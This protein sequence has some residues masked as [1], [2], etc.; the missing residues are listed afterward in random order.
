MR[1]DILIRL[2]FILVLAAACAHASVASAK[3]KR[4]RSP[5]E[6]SRQVV[7]VTTPDWTSVRGTLRRFERKGARSKWTQVGPAFA[8][9]VGRSGLGCG[10]GLAE[11]EGEGPSKREG[12][13]RAPAG[14]FRL[15]NAF[16]F[17]DTNAASWLRL[18]YTPLT[19]AVE[20][21]DDTRAD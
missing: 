6:G 11:S 7:L 4:K 17:A 3:T 19:P 2:V 16:G 9:V 8:I 18:P 12:D 10:E 20:G 5:L 13:G 21:V 15:M 14:V 1:R